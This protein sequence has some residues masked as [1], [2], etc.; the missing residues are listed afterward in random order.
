VMQ[1]GADL[2]QYQK[3]LASLESGMMTTG[4]LVSTKDRGG[5][6]TVI[7]VISTQ[8]LRALQKKLQTDQYFIRGSRDARVSDEAVREL[9]KTLREA[10]LSEIAAIQ[11]K[12]ES[13]EEGIQEKEAQLR[14]LEE[15][16]EN[17]RK[18]ELAAM[19]AKERYLQYVAK[20]EEARLE[21]LK[22]SGRLINVSVVVKPSLPITPTF[23][24]TGLFVL[25]A[26]FLAFPLGIGIIL[27]INFFDHTFNNPKEIE[28]ASGYR[29]IA[30]LG[31]L[32]SSVPKEAVK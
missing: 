19:I 14:L 6:N 22:R 12:K 15:K 9:T 32:S 8:L 29:V 17:S 26:F 21:N 1:L 30:V 7:A 5:E 3:I 24:K 11:A 2:D 20:E 27:V 10:I 13:L 25:G 4:Q 28:A 16:S 31:K 18:L 23:P